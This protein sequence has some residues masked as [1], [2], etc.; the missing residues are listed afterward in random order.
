MQKKFQ[1]IRQFIFG[2]RLFKLNVIID[3][4]H[5]IQFQF[6]FPI[7]TLISVTRFYFFQFTWPLDLQVCEWFCKI[8][9]VLPTQFIRYEQNG[10]HRTF[11]R[12]YLDCQ[13]RWGDPSIPPEAEGLSTKKNI[14]KIKQKI[15]PMI[16]LSGTIMG[17]ST[18]NLF[19]K[20]KVF[21][22]LFL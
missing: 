2:R 14:L 13:Q 5:R 16:F 1:I 19:Y 3:D 11:K 7:F 8:P 9:I 18:N 12:A 10:F 15:S 6:Q 22:S 17:L 4:S 21:F 20:K